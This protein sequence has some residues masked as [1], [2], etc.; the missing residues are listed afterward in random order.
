MVGEGQRRDFFFPK[1]PSILIF[2]VI[3]GDISKAYKVLLVLVYE[4]TELQGGQV[5]VVVI[6]LWLKHG[7][8]VL[9]ILHLLHS[10]SVQPK[11]TYLGSKLYTFDQA[12]Q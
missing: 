2:G 7:I 1:V 10:F 11:C 9:K 4:C 12:V 3:E 6:C 8:A 5:S